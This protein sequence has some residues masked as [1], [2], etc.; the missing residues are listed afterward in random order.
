MATMAIKIVSTACPR[1]ITRA[2]P[3]TVTGA[4]GVTETMP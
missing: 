1:D 2:K 3:N 4:L